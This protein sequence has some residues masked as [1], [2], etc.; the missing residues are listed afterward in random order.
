MT[1][2]LKVKSHHGLLHIYIYIWDYCKKKKNSKILDSH[3]GAAKILPKV[4]IAQHHKWTQM[5]FFLSFSLSACLSVCLSVCVPVYFLGPVISLT[6][7]LE[8]IENEICK[9]QNMRR[10]NQNIKR[11]EMIKEGGGQKKA[12]LKQRR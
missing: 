10:Q 12:P 3:F 6:E 4:H 9:I 11:N 2:F 5:P 8:T 7:P 1:P